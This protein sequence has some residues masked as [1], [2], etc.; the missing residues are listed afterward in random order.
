MRAS[1]I[2][3]VWNGA[4]DLPDCLNA[5][6]AHSGNE[7]EEV[8]CVDNASEDGSATLISKHYPD[9]R[10]VQQPVNLGFAG[11]VNAGI[12]RAQGDVF[13]LLNQDTVVNPGWLEALIGVFEDRPEFGIAGCTI[14]NPDGTVHHAGAKITRPDAY[15]E[16]LLDIGDSQP[17]RVEYVTGAAFAV[18]R[19]TWDT[20]G[21]FDE[22]YYPVYYEESDYCY[23]ARN[24]NIETAY[25]PKARVVHTFTGGERVSEPIKLHANHQRSRY[26]FVSKHFGPDE[27]DEFFEAELAAIENERYFTY[28][29]A[30]AIAARDT[31]R[32][33]PD[34]VERRKIDLDEAIT[35]VHR[36]QL[37][38]GFSEIWRQAFSASKRLSPSTA[39]D[40]LLRD[41]ARGDME[42]DSDTRSWKRSIRRHLYAPSPGESASIF[43]RAI[44][45]L[46][47]RPVR[48]V[49]D[50]MRM[51]RTWRQMNS[52]LQ[53]IYREWYVLDIL[54]D[55]EYR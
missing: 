19:E 21:Q 2:I 14:V 45:L 47:T 32:G 17:R 5:L 40:G 39:G 3:P 25:V 30:R 13:V 16:H 43:R 48:L 28:A 12:E 8:I 1:I 24:R 6:Y 53:D 23:R 35:P 42:D 7:L 26:R 44:W 52:T 18:R 41:K 49:A 50:Q 38:V 37:Q 33:V 55:Y 34:V 31:I 51:F 11:G 10:L 20:V 15:G 29:I 9:V 27:I 54:T 4:S 22:G 36:R 46:V